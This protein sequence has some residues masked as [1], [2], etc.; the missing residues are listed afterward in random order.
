MKWRS[1][2]RGAAL[3]ACAAVALGAGNRALGT[4]GQLASPMYE[5]PSSSM[6][7]F[8]SSPDYRV[9]EFPGRLVCLP[10][11]VAGTP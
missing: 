3:M 11:G 1:T 4:Q 7:R 5:D 9:G 6:G 8:Y 10:C 2:L